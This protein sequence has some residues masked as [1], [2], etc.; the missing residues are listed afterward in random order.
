VQQTTTVVLK[1]HVKFVKHDKHKYKQ[2]ETIMPSYEIILN[3][4]YVE[5]SDVCN[6]CKNTIIYKF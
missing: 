3:H 5:F 1:P 2:N 4:N 6:E